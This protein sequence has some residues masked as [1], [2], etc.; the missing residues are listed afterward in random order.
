MSFRL[1]KE[2]LPATWQTIIDSYF[3]AFFQTRKYP[4]FFQSYLYLKSERKYFYYGFIDDCFILIK[5]KKEF[6]NRV[7]YLVLPPIHYKGDLQAELNLI[8]RFRTQGI[9]T[10]L[11]DED[12]LI[13]KYNNKLIRKEKDNIEHVYHPEDFISTGK[14]FR[15]YY[16]KLISSN[17]I[18]INIKYK[19]SGSDITDIERLINNWAK[20]KKMQPDRCHDYFNDNDLNF[21]IEVKHAGN[22]VTSTMNEVIMPGKIIMAT[23]YSDYY[24][25][26]PRLQSNKALH[27]VLMNY[28]R[29]N[30]PDSLINSGSGGW[31]KGLT[32]HKE[33]MRPCKKLQIFDTKIENKL[34]EE[35]YQLICSKAIC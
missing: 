14:K 5:R 32:A 25:Q 17:E 11:S 4:R 15:Y 35:E 20:Y 33:N 7:C 34:T 3:P 28:C 12:I 31:D 10:K 24:H 27:M 1:F 26:I 9:K 18:D 21:Y 19:L 8:E 29:E 2:M 13:Y 6:G 16:N 23:N 30:H 22:I